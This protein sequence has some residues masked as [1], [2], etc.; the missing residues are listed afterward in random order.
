[1]ARFILTAALL[2]GAATPGLSTPDGS[3]GKLNDRNWDVMLSQYPP[4]SRAA[5]EQGPVG[6]RVKLDGEGYASE[7]VVTSS[8]GY[9]L[10]D[11]ETCRLIMIRG[12]FRGITDEKG[13]RASGVFEGV[14]RW[15]LPGPASVAATS[16]AAQPPPPRLAPAPVRIAQ[17][18]RPEKMICRRK[19]RTGSLAEFER[20]CMTESDWDR[21]TDNQRAFWQD[22]QGIRGVGC[23]PPPCEK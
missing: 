10:L 18:S 21:H 9:P 19:L 1:M 17:A 23:D 15:Q 20:V 6:F 3:A 22:L 12:E 7:C 5:R 4:R 13:R 11:N 2:A 16:A 14:V 8:S